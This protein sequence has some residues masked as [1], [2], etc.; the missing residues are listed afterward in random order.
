MLLFTI[1][2]VILH[3]EMSVSCGEKYAIVTNWLTV[4]QMAPCLPPLCKSPYVFFVFE[5]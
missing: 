1:N 3:I 4:L 5:K 2:S